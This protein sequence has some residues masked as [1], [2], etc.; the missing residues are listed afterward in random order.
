MH[1]CVPINTKINI[2]NLRNSKKTDAVQVRKGEKLEDFVKKKEI[3]NKIL[4]K[5]IEEINHKTKK[6][7]YEK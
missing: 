7:S 6:T 2:M 4:T 1:I 3:Q 5:I